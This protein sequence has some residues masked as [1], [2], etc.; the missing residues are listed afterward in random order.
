M[1]L[2]KGS[3][4]VCAGALDAAAVTEERGKVLL[5]FKRELVTN[6]LRACLFRTLFKQ[7]HVFLPRHELARQTGKRPRLSRRAGTAGGFNGFIFGTS[8]PYLTFCKHPSLLGSGQCVPSDAVRSGI[9][10]QDGPG[11]GPERGGSPPPRP[12]RR[13]AHALTLA[14]APASPAGPSS[15]RAPSGAG[16]AA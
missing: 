15:P 13:G 9:P 4:W 8:L 5:T 12:R 6:S 2:A 11:A 3:G 16:A 10:L 7:P 1:G 14:D